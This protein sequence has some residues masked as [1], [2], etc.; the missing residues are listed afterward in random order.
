MVRFVLKLSSGLEFV[1]FLDNIHKQQY[2]Q[3]SFHNV[4]GNDYSVVTNYT[5]FTYKLN[6]AFN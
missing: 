2:R 4:F 5:K 6:A 3:D 1:F